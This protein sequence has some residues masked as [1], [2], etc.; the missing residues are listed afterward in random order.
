MDAF[1]HE[2]LQTVSKILFFYLGK[3]ETLQN[4]ISFE[5]DV[6]HDP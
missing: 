4:E 2:I 1:L 3:V 6:A 5:K